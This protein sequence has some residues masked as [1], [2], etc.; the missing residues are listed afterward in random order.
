[1]HCFSALLSIADYWMQLL[2]NLFAC[3]ILNGVIDYYVFHSALVAGDKVRVCGPVA[4]FIF[5][6]INLFMLMKSRSRIIELIK[7]KKLRALPDTS[8]RGAALA[9]LFWSLRRTSPNKN[10]H[11][12]A[13]V[14]LLIGAVYFLLNERVFPPPLAGVENLRLAVALESSW[15]ALTFV[16]LFSMQ[17]AASLHEGQQE[18]LAPQDT[19]QT[20]K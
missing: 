1:M 5:V 13:N 10:T 6:S 2:I 18:L 3:V 16:F 19:K 20:L 4:V 14:A 8:Y 17:Y 12:V 7:E 11:F 15:K 9:P